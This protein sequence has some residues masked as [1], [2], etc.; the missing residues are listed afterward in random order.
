M[1]STLNHDKWFLGGLP[2]RTARI[3][4]LCFSHAG[5]GASTFRAW[6]FLLPPDF[7]ACMIQLPGRENRL[8]ERPYTRL[9]PLIET[10]VRVLEPVLHEP[11]AFFGHSMG[12][13]VAFE[14][15]RA[16]R[17][18]GAPQ[19]IHLL[20]A[21]RQPPRLPALEPLLHGRPDDEF[22]AE[23]RRLNG[24]SDGVFA[25]PELLRLITPL[26]RADM[27]VC[28]TYEYVNA[29][30]LACRLSLFAARDDAGATPERMEDWALETTSG[31]RFHTFAG[32]HFFVH[33]DAAAVVAKVATDLNET[34]ERRALT[35]AREPGHALPIDRDAVM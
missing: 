19:P 24:T 2:A 22:L 16:L 25:H 28:E 13:L 8:A 5:A 3:R 32:D 27:A 6:P 10:L 23:I 26:L 34:L 35:P 15:A 17:E 18:V 29:P 21:A 14:L 4:L 20:I 33:R 11:F 31:C 30:P 1:M 9:R 12:G 7:Q